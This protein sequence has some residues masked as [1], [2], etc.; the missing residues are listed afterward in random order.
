MTNIPQLGLRDRESGVYWRGAIVKDE[1]LSDSYRGS[2][3]TAYRVDFLF[4]PSTISVSHDAGA[5]L[6]EDQ[7]A[8]DGQYVSA[9]G[10]GQV[11]FNLL[12]DRTYE[13][14]SSYGAGDARDRGVVADVEALYRVTG[15]YDVTATGAGATQIQPMQSYNCYFYFGGDTNNGTRPAFSKAL[16]YYGYISQLAVNYTHFSNTMVPQRCGVSI[17]VELTQK[18]VDQ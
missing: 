4:N 17:T 11:S 15:V 18:G 14:N 10:I 5:K 7:Q 9:S 3:L 2:K 1:N 6:T 12:F 16:F 8:T 13:V